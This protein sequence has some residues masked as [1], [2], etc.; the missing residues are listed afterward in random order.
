[1]KLLLVPAI[2]LLAVGAER[3]F[4]AWRGLTPVAIDCAELARGHASSQRVL[5]TGC[6]LAYREAGYLRSG[7]QVSDLYLP[8]RPSGS[9]GP[10]PIVVATRS[11]AALEAAQASVGDGGH[12]PTGGAARMEEALRPVIVRSG[13][14]A[15]LIRGGAIERARTRRILAGLRGPVAED[16]IVVDLDGV[17]DFVQPGLA[18]GGGVLLAALALRR[19]REAPVDADDRDVPPPADEGLHSEP[20]SMTASGPTPLAAPALPRVLLLALG[21]S[22]GPEAVETAPPLGARHDVIRRVCEIV[23]DLHTGHASRI[24]AR[25]DSSLTLDTG[26]ADPIATI[27]VDTRGEGGVALL[28]EILLITGWRAFVPKTGMFVTLDEL[29][30]IAALARTDSV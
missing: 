5:I 26:D 19:R 25:A 28:Q 27:I 24:L 22:A 21:A 12:V 13:A 3:G 16:A 29:K 10:A 20:R 6:D 2:V 8:A 17:P 30:A 7:G 1:M 4:H 9:S 23:P 14:I 15:G 11:A 18:I